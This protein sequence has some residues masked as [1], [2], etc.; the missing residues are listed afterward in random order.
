M[1][2]P[3]RL[4]DPVT[5]DMIVP[6]GVIGP[7]CFPTVMFEFLPAARMGDTVI[8]SGVI[9]VGM[10]HPPP[11]L[12]VPIVTGNVRVLTGFMPQARWMIDVAACG[13]FLGDPKLMA[14]RRVFLGA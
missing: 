13:T 4:P 10:V 11:P 5:H 1:F 7:T 6:S 9:S 2:P 8:C 12:P 3:A 14:T